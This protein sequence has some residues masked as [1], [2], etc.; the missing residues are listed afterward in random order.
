MFN[1][2]IKKSSKFFAVLLT[3][4]LALTPLSYA[5][6]VNTYEGLQDEIQASG[7]ETEIN[8]TD[9]ITATNAN[10][11]GDQ[12]ADKLTING[13]NNTINGEYTGG[14]APTNVS[15]MKISE[16]Q[17]TNINNINFNNFSAEE[18]G[19]VINNNKG[20]LSVEKSSFSYNQAGE[21]G[22]AIRH[23]SNTDSVALTVKDSSFTANKAAIAG[24]V[25]IDGGNTKFED[26]LFEN[27]EAATIGA[28]GIFFSNPGDVTEL[29]RVE[30][31][32][33][34]STG[35]VSTTDGYAGAF[36][37]A[38]ASDVRVS[39][40]KFTGNEATKDGGAISTRDILGTGDLSNG[41]LSIVGSTFTSNKAGNYGGAID[42]YFYKSGNDNSTDA[43]YVNDSLFS[44]NEALRGGAIY[45]RSAADGD[46]TAAKMLVENSTFTANFASER[47]SAIY[48]EGNLTVKTSSFTG[49]GV[50]DNDKT[51][52]GGAIF[53]GNSS[54][55]NIEDSYFGSNQAGV[56]GGAIFASST[57]GDTTITGSVFENNYAGQFGGAVTSQNLL[58]VKESTFN[59][60]S[61]EYGGAV[62]VKRTGEIK[63][64][65][66]TGNNAA[67]GGAV[68]TDYAVSDLTI[69]T[70]TF[71]ENY[72]GG[73]GAVGLFNK[74]T[75]KNNTFDGN[76]TT[77]S[78]NVDGSGAILIGADGVV[79]IDSNTFINNTSASN[80]GAIGT[81]RAEDAD[82]SDA[83]L[84]IKN[85]IFSNNV[86]VSS[87]G[88]INNYFYNSDTVSGSVYVEN[89]KFESN[90][91]AYGGAIY[92]H[93]ELDQANNSAAML[94][95]GSTFTSNS[96]SQY[97]GAIYN[98]S[99]MTINSSKFE[100][101]YVGS[102][103]NK[104]DIYNAG[105]LNFN[106]GTTT[107]TGG[108]TGNG[109]T[110]IGDEYNTNNSAYVEL[111]NE[112][113]LEQAEI[114]VAQNSE[115]KANAANI[116]LTGNNDAVY[117]SGSLVLYSSATDTI[118]FASSIRD[119][120]NAG[121]TTIKTENNI[122]AN[123]DMGDNVLQQYG[124]VIEEGS[125]LF[126]NAEN[127]SISSKVVNSGDLVFNGGNSNSNIVEGTGNLRIET[128]LTNN[129]VISQSTVSVGSNYGL[130]NTSSIT[131]NYVTANT[132]QNN[133]E[134]IL[135]LTEDAGY[136]ITY[137]TGNVGTSSITVDAGNSVRINNTGSIEQQ[138]IYTY[139]AGSLL[140]T[141]N[142]I[143]ANIVN[144]M[145]GNCLDLATR[146]EGTLENNP[147]NPD[148]EGVV[149][150]LDGGSVSGQITNSSGTINITAGNFNVENGITSENTTDI[151]KNIINIGSTTARSVVVSTTA[152]NYQTINVS[153]GSLTLLDEGSSNGTID[154]SSVTVSAVSTFTANASRVTNTTIQN[155]GLVQFVGGTETNPSI[156]TSTITASNKGTININGVLENQEG[157]GISKQDIQVLETST[158]T[159][160]ASDITNSTIA[161]AGELVFFGTSEMTNANVVSGLTDDDGNTIY[162]K[163]SI[164]SALVNNANIEQYDIDVDADLTNNAQIT[165]QGTLTNNLSLGNNSAI[166]AGTLRNEDTGV[167]TN[168]SG[169]TVNVTDDFVNTG[170]VDNTGTI[171]V[172]NSDT[173]AVLT[174]GE[175]A[176]IINNAGGSISANS[177][178]NEDG[179]LI[180]NKASALIETLTLNNNGTI[181]STGSINANVL[182]NNE[183]ASL[184]N[185]EYGVIVSTALTN[186][187]AI[188]SSGSITTYR[189]LSNAYI[190]SIT[191]SSGTITAKEIDNNG[192]IDNAEKASISA[193]IF[194][195]D[196]GGT[197]NNLGAITVSDVL[198]NEGIIRSTGS[199]EA[200]NIVNENGGLIES[201]RTNAEGSEEY[202]GGTITSANQIENKG[203]ITANA[204]GVFAE[205]YNNGN[206]EAGNGV[207]N[208]MGGTISY[209]VS[210][211]SVDKSTVNV[212]GQ[213]TVSSN[214]FISQNNIILAQDSELI[215]EK[216]S[217]LRSSALIIG[218]NSTFNIMNGSIDTVDI[219][220]M[221][222]NSGITWNFKFDVDLKDKTTDMLTN[223]NF[224]SN[225][226]MTITTINVLKDS[227]KATTT[228]LTIADSYT[229]ADI[230]NTTFAT[231]KVIYDVQQDMN[232]STATV[233]N[234]TADGYG[235][236]PNAV[237]DGLNLYY[238]T[239]ES[240]E[241]KNEYVRKWITDDH[242]I[243]DELVA[244]MSINGNDT[245][246]V[247]S[248]IA[249]GDDPVS[250]VT[251][252]KTGS[253]TLRINDQEDA[254]GLTVKGFENAFYVNETD[255][256]LEAN[257]VVFSS[258]TGNAVISNIGTV[259]L[260]SVTFSNNTAAIDVSNDGD[261]ILTGIGSTFQNGIVGQGTTTIK[262]TAIDMG[263]A[264]LAQ[265]RID[266]SDVAGSSLTVKVANLSTST[267][268]GYSGTT[269]LIMNH[270]E[271]VLIGNE[272]A[273]AADLQTAVNGIGSTE[274]QKSITVS[275]NIAQT[276]VN[277]ASATVTVG[278][279]AKITATT[280]SVDE[281]SSLTT[282]A[283]NIDTFATNGGINN[284]G[285]IIF[286]GGTNNNTIT[287]EQGK[288][289]IEMGAEVI[290]STGTQISQQFIEVKETAKFA[291]NAD[292]V[293]TATT[294]DL[295][296][297]QNNGDLEITGGT[298]KNIIGR[299][300]AVTGNLII[301]GDVANKEGTE[302]D[303][304]KITVNTGASFTAN[305]SDLTADNGI[306]NNSLL[307]FIGG[308][309]NNVIDGSGRLVI[310]SG[311]AVTNNAAIAQTDGLVIEQYAVFSS[312]AS[313]I[314]AAI[315][316][317][318]TLV[319]N[320]GLNNDTNGNDII[321]VLGKL[322]ID[323]ST[324]VTNTAAIQQKEMSIVSSSTFVTSANNFSITDGIVNG[325]EL[326]YT[327][328]TNINNITG[329]GELVI[330]GDVTNS[331][332][333]TISQSTITI[334]DQGI[335][336]TL[337]TSVTTEKGIVNDGAL[338]YTG[339]INTS[340]ITTNAQGTLTVLDSLTN[341]AEITQD[342]VNI[343]GGMFT[344]VAG[345][346]I[347]ANTEINIAAEGN[348]GLTTDATDI[349]ETTINNGGELIFVSDSAMT[350]LSEITG[351]GN[352]TVNGDLTSGKNIT[353]TNINILSGTFEH[354]IGDA[355]DIATITA[356]NISVSTSATFVIHS[357]VIAND[358]ITNDGIVRVNVLQPTGEADDVTSENNIIGKGDLIISS[359]NYKNDGGLI[360]QKTLT[361]EDI[362]SSF[363]TD[364]ANFE[365]YNGIVTEGRL[366]YTGT[367]ISSSTIVSN[368][369]TGELIIGTADTVA[370]IINKEGN[371]VSLSTITVN[372][373]SKFKAN[374][375][376]LITEAGIV[377]DGELTFTGG[378]NN[379]TITRSRSGNEQLLVEGNLQ[380]KAAI[381]QGT[382][383]VNSDFFNNV[384][385][386]SITAS[387]FT[388]NTNFITDAY[389]LTISTI[390]LGA[391]GSV[392]RLMDDEIQGKDIVLDS[393]ID[394]TGSIVKEGTGI[395]TL[396]GEN[397]Y[398]G[399]TAITAGAIR[400]S[401][402]TNISDADDKN[403]Y[404]NGGKLIIAGNTEINGNFVGT[405]Y[406]TI[407]DV[408]IEVE[409]VV[410]AT[411]TA[412]SAIYGDGNLVKTGAGT[413]NLEMASNGY[414]GNTIVSSGTLRGTTANINGILFGTGSDKLDT[415]EFYDEGTDVVLN[416]VSDTDYIGTFN[417]TG[418]STMTVTK[419]FKA[420]DVNISSGTFVINNDADMIS[421]DV[422]DFVATTMT[423][424][425]AM[426]KG[427][428]DLTV[429]KLIIGA[430]ATFAPGNSTTTY[431]VSGDMEFKD[432]STYDVEFGQ[433]SMDEEGHYNDNTT[434]GGTTT[435]E[436][437]AK[438][439]LNNLEGKYYAHE[440]IDLINAG[441]LA[442]FEYKGGDEE[443]DDSEGYNKIT[444]GNVVFKDYDTRDLRPGYD[445][446][447]T[448]RVYVQDNALKLDLERKASEYSTSVEFD[449]SHNEQEAANSIDTISELSNSGDIT[450]A[451]DAM[452]KFYYYNET[453]DIPAL[454]AALNDIAGVIHANSTNLTFFNA[455]AEHVYDKIKGRT[456]DLYPCTKFH[457]KIWAEYYYNN[458]NVEKDENSPKYDS[459]V[460]GFLVG[461][462]ML[463]VKGWTM[464][465]MG[466]YGTSEL[467]Q[468]EDK[469]SMS[470]INLGFYGGYIGKK[471]E[472]KGMLLGGY[473]QYSIDRDIAF[474]ERRATSDHKGYSAALDLE[475][476]YKI[477]LNENSQ[478]NH[479]LYLTPFIG[480]MGGYINNEGY[481]EKGGED[482]NLKI[483][484]Y[485]NLTAEARAG[486]GI[487]GK[488]KKFG[489][490][491][492]AGVRQLLTEK[493]NEIELSLLNFEEY[494][495]MK[496]RSAEN[497]QTTITGGIGADYDL[498][499][500]WTIF[501]NGLGNFADASTNYYANVGLSY[502][503]S[504]VNNKSRE[505]E[506]VK[507]YLKDVQDEMKKKDDE[508]AKLQDKVKKYEQ[509]EK[510]LKNRMQKYEANVVSEEK[511]QKMKKKVIKNMRLG[512]KPTFV[513]GTDKLNS[514]GKESLRQVARE[515][516]N[517]P[518]ADVLIEGH[519]DNVGSDEV[520]Q[521]ISENRASTVAT[522]LKRDFNVKNDI[523]VIG[524]GKK[525][526][527]ASNATAEG[528]AKNRRVE[529]ILTTD[530]E[531]V[532]SMV[533]ANANEVKTEA[534]VKANDVKKDAEKAA[535]EVK[536]DAEKTANEV[537]KEVKEAEVKAQNQ[538]QNE[539]PVEATITGKEIK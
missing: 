235:G 11:L 68:Y 276:N 107:F 280:V 177:I 430:G 453:Y 180:E 296:G 281:D 475:A 130:I 72:A 69:S 175:N 488:V 321:G 471:W 6:D 315:N 403:I 31:K 258:N 367:G 262:G 195:N 402:A 256:R 176:T 181:I 531:E 145:T 279:D 397:E 285:N 17:E 162:G 455:K 84:D 220:S 212:Q 246:L 259:V 507:Q 254:K 372:E 441:S 529:I 521:K 496:I 81:R 116:R 493:Y 347:T 178:I 426:L 314:D 257:N 268:S 141:G 252:L 416:E 407:N 501:A 161:N 8:V 18:K 468:R 240:E 284:E 75:L 480:V 473:E 435:I 43:V 243:H 340:S 159:A 374:A 312:T 49:N 409:D 163:L 209:N 241:D 299:G 66:F 202:E 442:D 70:T 373:G 462:D 207:Y 158:F 469:T 294:G 133:G 143:V 93:G 448:T 104:N 123:I 292:D 391:E 484:G 160:N 437:D 99:T 48:N 394:G 170:L 95:A 255:G 512:E 172:A 128:N 288:I 361:I 92:N 227:E 198:E 527:I 62:Y 359:T 87:G 313:I 89:T 286:V 514:R 36:L 443:I 264:V 173:R 486:L 408:N 56:Y 188:V 138:T 417:K 174:N 506:E 526:P 520:N 106:I 46:G 467:K 387:Q 538:V 378:I 331:L 260:S 422:Y 129:N 536:K 377:N 432:K 57:A 232:V 204:S 479:K 389:D 457:D 495:K 101:N 248:P 190:A 237:Y 400:I 118:N 458:Y 508:I 153:S 423:V 515:L 164:E 338:F 78:N 339:G 59:N 404:M 283:N 354:N 513:F 355:A 301:S 236:L 120:V 345:S 124:L 392:L 100:N 278:D 137:L 115:L 44:K 503:F 216:E 322:V 427:Y 33:N 238:V 395:V 500:N 150:I 460:N 368:N 491:A 449:R 28:L 360:S 525:E 74:A 221:T 537:K 51:S 511:A 249:T 12:G 410:T 233:L 1:K 154:T 478:S 420:S 234:I 330:S 522:T 167:L 157:T 466:G 375:S 197:I 226:T 482:L 492:K 436:E 142:K 206:G 317:E 213:V 358:Q 490:Y 341:T 85:S 497:A 411:A 533:N 251:G 463:S 113:K 304:E 229:Y 343:I 253:F 510:D 210:G 309:N 445:T 388:A 215:L 263:D 447:I 136:D 333:A 414:T 494:S 156:N 474:M 122:G 189:T 499:D 269:E 498:S 476:D 396:T 64:S 446:R 405:H 379:S 90:Q 456:L 290:N 277:L 320:S 528:R 519:T 127:L 34:K 23:K 61:G 517:Y 351:E 219:S 42:N 245:V 96:A 272:G 459:T 132:L 452:E 419:Y 40:S 489:W 328:G 433:F 434:V 63:D 291:M 217:N 454:K 300:D 464:G 27:N 45:N 524:K 336:E 187:G 10:P 342:K 502:K 26:T 318:G 225:S 29:N 9:N 47:A 319:F 244:D 77:D 418:S 310:S 346:S 39:N 532:E 327:D 179:A 131:A 20:T 470:D 413:L 119:A 134:L 83:K 147:A 35:T 261:L 14:E 54:I 535:N 148:T 155:D 487:K 60:N 357:E 53:V 37:A 186:N 185:E 203:T 169:A 450:T 94:I 55:T 267:A 19:A 523:S 509:N 231:T 194:Y 114:S 168:N 326:E 381:E 22:G 275:T 461:F 201:Y 323:S 325:G 110:Y 50:K 16:G 71:T 303:Q 337:A 428:G 344:N 38:S 86:A 112:A 429:D 385:G 24:A 415:F 135:N 52:Y 98:A 2:F 224:A 465:I 393:Y 76:Y 13:N 335:F 412:N 205:I 384:R 332:G 477:A 380:N 386:S 302:I 274:L 363:E 108:I 196:Y 144:Y 348:A 73:V 222:V 102:E 165:A 451:L 364:I 125:S 265:N 516:E 139:G 109:S 152:I 350:N 126:V 239:G 370:D 324:T 390:T 383:I 25:M 103:D 111:A 353:Q 431:K 282:N 329:D 439:V 140:L 271:L 534:E 334:T 91:A 298:N 82:N 97:G 15:G 352:L 21:F 438:I 406:D 208:V 316:N 273:D 4:T 191:N 242:G 425:N 247:S 424:T 146:I 192:L 228:S 67:H 3:V 518:D 307:T 308:T 530:E 356:D 121:T 250:P 505:D 88:A 293:E 80:A 223:T 398:E 371:E 289:F 32:G 440:T 270:G 149:N 295:R 349:A 306:T 485:D 421:G 311:A 399:F 365:A 182:N 376:N 30:F 41:A 366:I 297:I 166:I 218:Q 65:V 539:K 266:I 444:I 5:A 184:F 151:A 200:T 214:A 193:E 199:I 481:E 305:A 369:K 287:G 472:L 382:I 171:T 79:V 105:Q 183:G 58:T 230:L 117:N 362:D 7:S 483:E 504:C 401:S 211:I